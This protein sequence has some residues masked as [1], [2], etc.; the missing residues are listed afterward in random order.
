MSSGY[1]VVASPIRPGVSGVRY[2]WL[3]TS[4]TVFAQ[5]DVFASTNETGPPDSDPAAI[6]LQ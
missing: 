1:T 2:F 3:N 6:P 4:G 5:D